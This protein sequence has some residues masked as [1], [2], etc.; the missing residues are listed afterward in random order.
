MKSYWNELQIFFSSWIFLTKRYKDMTFFAKREIISWISIPGTCLMISA[1]THF[2][3]AS[4]NTTTG[5]F[6]RKVYSIIDD[7][8]QLG[9]YSRLGSI[10]RTNSSEKMCKV[11]RPSF[12]RHEKS[13][14]ARIKLHCLL[15]TNLFNVQ[16][17]PPIKLQK[18]PFV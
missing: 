18:N 3:P 11:L 7:F 15:M 8:G 14:I 13:S 5:P 16:I 1:A 12:E 17:P 4:L 10:L 9:Q 2:A 6:V